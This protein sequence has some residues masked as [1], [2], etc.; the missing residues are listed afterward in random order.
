MMKIAT[1]NVNSLKVRL[2]HVLDWLK[3]TECDVLGLQELKLDNDA[4]A[5]LVDEFR[6]IGYNFIY[7]GQKTY[8]GV[9]LIS[10]HSLSDVSIDIPAYVDVQ[11]RV[12]AATVNGVRVICAYFVNGESIGSDKYQYKLEWLSH[13]HDYVE[14]QLKS[15]QQLVLLGD[16]NIAPE[17]RD[18]YDP[19][20]WEG[21]VLCSEPERQAFRNLIGLGLVDSLRYFNQEDRQFTWW[22]Y[23]NMAFRRKQGL[24]ID[25]LLVSP[26]VLE[27]AESCIIDTAPRKLERPSDHTPVILS[28]K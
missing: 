25:H 14:A 7:N 23:R 20:I 5:K 28:L 9:A 1:W 12:I 22:D 6:Q 27:R 4:N 16:Y 18:T 26:S 2:P 17:P 19:A 21:Q 13:L 10:K 8:N 11:K 15:H 24:R 3:V